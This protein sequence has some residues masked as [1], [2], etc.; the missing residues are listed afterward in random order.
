M[1]R[2]QNIFE[3]GLGAYDHGRVGG[4]LDWFA[5]SRLSALP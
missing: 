5:F 1:D 2:Q 3:T 4:M